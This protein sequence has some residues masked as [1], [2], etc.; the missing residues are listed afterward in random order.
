MIEGTKGGLEGAKSLIMLPCVPLEGVVP[1]GMQNWD[2]RSLHSTW[3]ASLQS[4]K[5]NMQ[6]CLTL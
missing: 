1:L 2:K 5:R 3:H 6:M 4:T